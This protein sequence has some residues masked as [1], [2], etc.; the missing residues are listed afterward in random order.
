MSK[1]FP[2]LKAVGGSGELG[3]RSVEGVQVVVQRG[4]DLARRA[5]TSVAFDEEA[6]QERG[7][8]GGVAAAQK[9][10]SGM[11]LPQRL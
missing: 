2:Q 7:D 1:T 6:A 9:P 11:S 10:P 4:G 5:R 8:Q 3:D